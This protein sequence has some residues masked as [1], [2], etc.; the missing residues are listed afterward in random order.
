[1]INWNRLFRPLRHRRN[2]NYQDILQSEQDAPPPT[3]VSEEQV[4]ILIF[5]NV[6][7]SLLRS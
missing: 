7:K 6:M 3:E 4:N 2:A 5:L 1:M